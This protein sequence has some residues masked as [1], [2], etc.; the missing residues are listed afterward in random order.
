MES[1]QISCVCCMYCLY[2]FMLHDAYL[3]FL[4]NSYTLQVQIDAAGTWEIHEEMVQTSAGMLARV[5]TNKT[6]FGS[7]WLSLSMSFWY[8]LILFF[9]L[10]HQFRKQWGSSGWSEREMLGPEHQWASA[11]N[12][13]VWAGQTRMTRMGQRCQSSRST[14]L[15]ESIS[16]V[17]LSTETKGDNGKHR[18]T[19]LAVRDAD[20]LGRRTKWEQT[21][22]NWGLK[23]SEYGQ[24]V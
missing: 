18:V 3:H 24:I 15:L 21:G 23:W 12:R 11:W 20:R 22:R 9:F 14:N 5:S 1:D 8:F 10:G 4:Q 6:I 19:W 7:F 17:G 16:K 2:L 13:A